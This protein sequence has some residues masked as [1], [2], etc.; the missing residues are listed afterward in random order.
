MLS[1][2]K[3]IYTLAAYTKKLLSR[4][5]EKKCPKN[6]KMHLRKIEIKND[7]MQNE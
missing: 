3:V 2:K 1:G 4:K 7:N 5:K 6:K